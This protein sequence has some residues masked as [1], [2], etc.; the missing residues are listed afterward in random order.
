MRASHASLRLR[1]IKLVRLLRMSSSSITPSSEPVTVP[2]EMKRFWSRLRVFLSPLI[3][4]GFLAAM[5][6]LSTGELVP[7]RFVAWLQ[8]WQRPFVFLPR[9]SD[10]TY[11]LKLEGARMRKPEILVLGSSRA[12]QWRSA[13]FRPAG[14]F[15]GAN[16]IFAVGDFRNMLEALGDFSPKVIIFSMDYFTFMPSFVEVYKS[17]SKQDL[18]GLGSPEQLRIMQ[19]VALDA[20]QNP[21]LLFDFDVGGVPTF[22]LSA[23]VSGVG[24]R[25]D[26]SYD[27]KSVALPDIEN[28]LPAIRKGTQWPIPAG[29]RLDEQQLHEFERFTDLARQKKIALVGVTMPFLP[30]VTNAMEQSPLYGAWRQFLSPQTKDWIRKQGV[31]Y[32]DFTRLESFGGRP[33]EFADPFHPSEPAYIRM[34]LKML[35]NDDFRALVPGLDADRLKNQLK[36]ASRLTA[37]GNEY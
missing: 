25:I 6:G 8:T 30:G 36:Q 23:R 28:V 18:D 14:A 19:S 34:L 2:A 33:D 31:L 1:D 9:Y 37:F 16:A 12:N 3:L 27:Y 5:V 24:F 32:F 29:G 26:G 11:E 15:N 10:H 22:G 17:Q 20:W 13:M 35:E 4:I 21:A 7:V